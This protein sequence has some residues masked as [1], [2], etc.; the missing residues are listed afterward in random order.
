LVQNHHFP[1]SGKSLVEG[2]CSLAFQELSGQSHE[3]LARVLLVDG[4]LRRQK[5]G[6]SLFIFWDRG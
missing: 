1:F 6:I 4:K 2:F 3:V 5:S